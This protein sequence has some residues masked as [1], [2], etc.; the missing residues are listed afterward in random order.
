MERSDV[1]VPPRT[2]NTRMSICK[3]CPLYKNKILGVFKTEK[4]AR[5]GSCGCFVRLKT[6]LI[7]MECPE[8]KW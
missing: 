6:Q 8:G 4:Y 1:L 3:A 7:G 2:A 5:C